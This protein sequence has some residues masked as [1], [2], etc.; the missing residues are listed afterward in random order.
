M[1]KINLAQEAIRN[2]LIARRRRVLYGVSTLVLL[3]TTGV[4]GLALFLTNRE[5]GQVE[6]VQRE[7][8]Q[9][10]S[11]L[12]ARESDVREAVLF[13]ERLKSLAKLLPNRVRWSRIFEELERLT[14]PN[15]AFVAIK[16]HV[17]ERAITAE[18]RV[19]SL[20]AAA[21]LIASLETRGDNATVF[22][23]VLA[24]SLKAVEESSAG[25]VTSIAGYRMSLKLITTAAAF[26]AP[27]ESEAQPAS[28]P[29]PVPSLPSPLPGASPATPTL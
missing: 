2:Q 1:P 9:L 27:A 24:T 8:A 7:T 3:V 13:R 22:T 25:G 28:S 21:D 5:R 26:S 4:Y 29:V 12:K 14:I 20:D 11:R 16:G 17:D 19:P 18:V 15:A 10:E 6:E 23:D